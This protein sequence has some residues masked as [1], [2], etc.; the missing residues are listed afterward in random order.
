SWQGS[1][2]TQASR[3]NQGTS[4][5]SATSTNRVHASKS[6]ASAPF[7]PPV[8]IFRTSLSPLVASSGELVLERRRC[9]SALLAYRT[10][11]RQASRGKRRCVG[12]GG[13]G[14]SRSRSRWAQLMTL[15]RTTLSSRLALLLLL[16]VTRVVAQEKTSRVSV[17]S[18]GAQADRKSTRLNSSH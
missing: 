2:G 6:N 4:S 11:P 7:T 10:T 16:P 18:S 13:R 14:P 3:R 5:S 8:R 9:S 17:D 12:R 15:P 1:N